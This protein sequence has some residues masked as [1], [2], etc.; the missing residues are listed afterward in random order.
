MQ[1]SV[2]APRLRWVHIPVF[3]KTLKGLPQFSPTVADY[4]NL[5]KIIAHS[6]WSS[7]AG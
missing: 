7:R 5:P 2:G 3:P 6:R 1:P 4:K